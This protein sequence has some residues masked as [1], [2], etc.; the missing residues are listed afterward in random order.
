MSSGNLKPKKRQSASRKTGI[1]AA[2][3]TAAFA[4]IGTICMIIGYHDEVLRFLRTTAIAFFVVA[5]FPLGVFVYNLIN[6]KI[7]S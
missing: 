7:D 1:V 3:V 2:A 6:K 5:L 4:V